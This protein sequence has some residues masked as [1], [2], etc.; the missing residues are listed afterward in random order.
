MWCT[1]L[2][3]ISVLALREAVSSY[4]ERVSLRYLPNRSSPPQNQENGPGGIR[5]RIC[6][7]DRVLC[8]RYTTGPERSLGDD[9]YDGNGRA[10]VFVDGVPKWDGAYVGTRVSPSFARLLTLPR[11]VLTRG[12]ETWKSSEGLS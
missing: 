1:A 9:A 6:N 5:T 7:L 11:S 8:C 10:E 4:L 2:C 3:P 12:A